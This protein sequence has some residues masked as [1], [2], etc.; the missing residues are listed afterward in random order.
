MG[1]LSENWAQH[2]HSDHWEDTLANPDAV[3][4]NQVVLKCR[5]AP[6]LTWS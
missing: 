5:I 2:Q 3:L 1:Q 6:I 4:D